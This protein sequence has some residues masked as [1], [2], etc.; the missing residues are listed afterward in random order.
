MF[1]SEYCFLHVN[2]KP[3][4]PPPTPAVEKPELRA[5][6]KP[7]DLFEGRYEIDCLIGSGGFAK[8]YKAKQTDLGREV[9][10]KIM[11]PA[12]ALK[13]LMDDSDGTGGH[14][15]AER[16]MQEARLIARLRDPHTVTM[17]D[18]GKSKDGLLYMVMEF[19]DGVPLSRLIKA[20]GALDARRVSK[21]LRQ[22]LSSLQEAHAFGMLHR[23]IKPGNI[24]IYEHVG[25]SDQ[26]KLLDFGIAKVVGRQAAMKQDLKEDLTTNGALLGTPRYMSP[27]QIR[28][29][30]LTPA[31]DLYSLGLVAYEALTGHKA[32]ESNSSVIVIGAQLDPRSFAVPNRGTIPPGL[33]MVVNR[34]LEKD[35]NLRYQSV[36]DVLDELDRLDTGAFPAAGRTPTLPP[37][38]DGSHEMFGDQL[39]DI[40]DS[41]EPLAVDSAEG[42]YK[43]R[44]RNRTIAAVGIVFACLVVGLAIGFALIGGGEGDDAD[45]VAASEPIDEEPAPT[46]E[47]PPAVAE[48]VAVA[49][50]VVEPPRDESKQ[51]SA[52][53]ITV[54]TVPSGLEVTINGKPFGT[55]PLMLSPKDVKFPAEFEAKLESGEAKHI[56]VNSPL[57]LVTL[58]LTSLQKKEPVKVVSKRTNRKTKKTNTPTKK[59]EEEPPKE[60]ASPSLVLPA[61]D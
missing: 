3:S 21:I 61:L 39:P 34:M 32:I 41:I 16:F 36:E 59:K 20:Q 12:E 49:P 38:S 7:G 40:S 43:T 8:V 57:R 26:A 9:A 25:R 58:D 52:E 47:P 53:A 45:A 44:K 50:E 28:G 55:S 15:L 35:R 18:H 5:F 17:H 14:K 30:D 13:E 27:E 56:R 6:P 42:A 33:R 1:H 46:E 24:M 22:C 51:L 4:Q 60:E 37:P 19:I 11:L 29:Q 2:P 10:L 48:E 23:D 31:S 54:E